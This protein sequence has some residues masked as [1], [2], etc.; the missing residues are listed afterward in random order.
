[1]AV[2]QTRPRRDQKEMI[3]SSAMGATIA[4][5]AEVEMTSCKAALETIF[6]MAVKGSILSV[7]PML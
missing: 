2:Q 3:G 1:M 4:F 6:S 5:S 7:L